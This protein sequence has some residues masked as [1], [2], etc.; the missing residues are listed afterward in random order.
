MV[1]QAVLP[2]VADPIQISGE[3][4]QYD[5]LL[6]LRVDPKNFRRLN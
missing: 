4:M 6:V 5:Q 3:V 2:F 1:N